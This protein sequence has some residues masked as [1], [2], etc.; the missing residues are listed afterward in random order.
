MQNQEPAPT[1]DP[2]VFLDM[3]EVSRRVGLRRSFIYQLAK[4]KKFPQP[5]KLT[6]RQSRWIESEIVEW[7]R[8]RVAE[9]NRAAA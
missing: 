1:A 5:V 4:D 2:V 7:Q 9:R 3:Q 6:E 8:A